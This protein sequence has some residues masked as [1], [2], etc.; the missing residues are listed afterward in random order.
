MPCGNFTSYSYMT[1]KSLQTMSLLT[2]IREVS[3]LMSDLKQTIS[4]ACMVLLII[5]RRLPIWCLKIDHDCSLFPSSCSTLSSHCR[6]CRIVKYR[7]ILMF[8]L[9]VLWKYNEIC[10]ISITLLHVLTPGLEMFYVAVFQNCSF[11]FN[12]EV[13]HVVYTD[14]TKC[15]HK[16]YIGSVLLHPLYAYFFS[17]SSL[18]ML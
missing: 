15:T 4:I 3:I 18:R 12:T 6:W 2:C 5:S 10:L 11:F 17:L 9:I 8:N 16:C 14:C 7:T 13:T 1:T